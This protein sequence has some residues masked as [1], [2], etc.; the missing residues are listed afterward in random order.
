MLGMANSVESKEHKTVDKQDL[1]CDHMHYDFML[2]MALTL[3]HKSTSFIVQEF[4]EL[5]EKHPR[6]GTCHKC[7]EE[8][9][10]VA[11]VVGE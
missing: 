8:A 11:G 9:E 5:I 10:L 6:C 1:I 7:L 2:G 4:L 3:G